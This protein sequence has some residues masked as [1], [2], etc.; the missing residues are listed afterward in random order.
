MTVGSW[1]A[2]I[3]CARG[4]FLVCSGSAGGVAALYASLDKVFDAA[5]PDLHRRQRL[6][7]P[8]EAA[9]KAAVCI[10]AAAD[11]NAKVGLSIFRKSRSHFARCRRIAG[12]DCSRSR[13]WGS[14]PGLT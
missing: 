12:S 9:V 11:T 4:P 1:A 7:T 13:D 6:I 8:I 10:K 2:G 5:L 14:A 3:T